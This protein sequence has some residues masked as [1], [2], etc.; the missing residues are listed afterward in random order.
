MGFRDED[1]A[2]DAARD[3]RADEERRRME[4]ECRCNS[5]S[6]EPCYYC[7]LR[8]EVEDDDYAT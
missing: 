1:E 7:Q 5:A 6:E 4:S 3:A 8:M 2:E